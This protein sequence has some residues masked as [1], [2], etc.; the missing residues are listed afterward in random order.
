[1]IQCCLSDLNLLSTEN[2]RVRRLD[3]NTL[4]EEFAQ[5]NTRQF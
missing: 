1:M 3:F 2:D 4:V 5:K